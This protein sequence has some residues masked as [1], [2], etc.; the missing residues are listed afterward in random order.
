M[1]PI[2]ID[3]CPGTPEG[4]SCPRR[5]DATAY[6]QG[7]LTAEARGAFARHLLDCSP[8]QEEV[9][10][11]RD[12]LERLW[13]A[14]R[15]GGSVDLAP[16]VLARA[17]ALE[18]GAAHRRTRLLAWAAVAAAAAF[19]A[20]LGWREIGSR[21]DHRPAA[22]IVERDLS[23]GPV[24]G[25]VS[26]AL[27]WLAATQ[28]PSGRWSA[29]RW[30]GHSQYDVG[31]TGMAALAFLINERGG[32]EGLPR[33]LAAAPD[34]AVRF[35]LREQAPGGRFGPEFPRTLYNH[36]IA[37]VALL[38]AL[39][40]SGD[41]GLRGPIERALRYI[42]R[43]RAPEGGWGYS[44]DGRPNT[45][46][47]CWPLQALLLARAQGFG[48]LD[49]PIRGGFEH[50]A[51]VSDGAGRLG[52]Q[53]RGD[54]PPGGPDTLSAM[55]AYCAAFAGDS[56]PA[57]VRGRLLDG[58]VRE[59]ASG[60][61][62]RDLYHDYFLSS[63]LAA[64]PGHR[65]GRWPEGASLQIAGRQVQEGSERGSWAPQ[66]PWGAAGGRIYSTAAAALILQADRRGQQLARWAAGG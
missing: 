38:E 54:S 47:T 44:D 19:L 15:D 12:L 5:V 35:L 40:R 9:R 28:E 31:V 3:D 30:G 60:N 46:L 13:A 1:L 57:E 39:A 4:P 2:S 25:A 33:V 17:R 32:A 48:G 52:Y 11:T 6:L 16:R 41:V 63:L 27:D 51:R 8:C 10:E 58:V 56:L 53:R 7:E 34:R 55:G 20:L 24:E 14:P 42:E 65:G 45:A 37:T 21:K 26:R 29:S 61:L 62:G 18:A 49:E 23:L 59:G 36:G 43:A 50:L 66:D 22:V 64:L